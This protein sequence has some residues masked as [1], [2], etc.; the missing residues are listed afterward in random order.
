MSR[1][2]KEEEDALVEM[3][4]VCAREI[5]QVL[6]FPE[7][8]GDRRLLRFYRG[9]DK[10]MKEACTLYANFLKWRVEGNVDA[11]RQEIV[12]GGRNEPR[13]FPHGEKLLRLAPQIIC[14]KACDKQNRPICTETYN[15]SPKVLFQES[16]PEEYLHFLT[17]ALEYRMICMEH[18]SHQLE[19]QYLAENPN[20]EDRVPGWGVVIKN[21]TIRDLKGVGLQH[22]G[23]EGRSMVM[24]AVKLGSPN[25]PDSLGKGVMIN[26]PHLFRVFWAGIKAFLDPDTVAKIDLLGTDYMNTLQQDIDFECIP[27]EFGGGYDGGN[28]PWGFDYSEN[29]PMHYPGAPPPPSFSP[30]P[31]K[32]TFSHELLFDHDDDD[33]LPNLSPN[34]SPWNSSR[35]ADFYDTFAAEGTHSNSS[36]SGGGGG[37][38]G[39][40]DGGI[41]RKLSPKAAERAIS[42]IEIPMRE[43]SGRNA[44]VRHASNGQRQQQQQLQQQ[45]HPPSDAKAQGTHDDN[46]KVKPE[47]SLAT[48]AR[49]LYHS[50]L[51]PLAQTA[52]H[53]PGTCSALFVVMAIIFLKNEQS[54]LKLLL[55][56]ALIFVIFK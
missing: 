11:I 46:R 45:L 32:S 17:Y 31:T 6:P 49:R 51:E 39:G 8:V 35:N 23:S 26:S 28:E 15:F 52:Y 48:W 47:S 42:Q 30:V 2:T 36:S 40:S 3:R 44:M 29:G 56:P 22:I 27:R 7:V 38:G 34:N 41:N 25:Y 12:Y 18:I 19:M 20:E 14:S 5:A 21:C 1:W 13:L 10:N 16:S 50:T 54:S 9:K 33:S 53:L 24:A 43:E 37:D 4:K 55:V